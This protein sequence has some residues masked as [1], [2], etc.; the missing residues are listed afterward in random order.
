MI[1][2]YAIYILIATANFV[3]LHRHNLTKTTYVHNSLH[4]SSL[5]IFQH[6]SR[7][8]CP[9]SHVSLDLI[10]KNTRIQLL[11]LLEVI[12]IPPFVN[13]RRLHRG[14]RLEFSFGLDIEI[15]KPRFNQRRIVIYRDLIHHGQ[16]PSFVAS[17]TSYL[18][19]HRA[20][21]QRP[22]DGQPFLLCPRHTCTSPEHPF[23]VELHLQIP[24]LP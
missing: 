17:I 9:N 7:H 5:S 20:I 19:K 8:K 15:P 3:T 11:H 18:Q 16:K 23:R 6:S 24:Q 12:A 13:Q 14:P 10:L 2:R 4:G 22:R 21:P 1:H